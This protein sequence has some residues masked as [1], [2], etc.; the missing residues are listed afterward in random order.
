MA[1][2]LRFQASANPSIQTIASVR[3]SGSGPTPARPTVPY[4]LTS[5]GHRPSC[6]GGNRVS[7]ILSASATTSVGSSSIRGRSSTIGVIGSTCSPLMAV[8]STIVSFFRMVICALMVTPLEKVA[9][10][11]REYA[12]HIG[13]CSLCSGGKDE[14]SGSASPQLPQWVA[15]CLFISA[16]STPKPVITA[17]VLSHPAISMARGWFPNRT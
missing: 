2:S 16:I 9:L 1:V 5:M 12:P 6:V 14:D 13:H 11:A 3:S 7:W 17:F 15:T 8:S 10:N 4:A